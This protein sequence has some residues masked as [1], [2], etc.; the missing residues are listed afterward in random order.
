MLHPET[1]QND[2]PL[3]QGGF[4]DVIR[5]CR[6]RIEDVVAPV[7]V[8]DRAVRLAIARPGGA[9]VLCADDREEGWHEVDQH[10]P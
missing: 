1:Q 7:G 9:R 8:E 6:V 10:A 4:D 2:A 3:S 5:L